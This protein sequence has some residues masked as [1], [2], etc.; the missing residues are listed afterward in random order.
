LK[1][2]RQRVSFEPFGSFES[3]GSFRS[4]PRLAY[5][6]AQVNPR[7]AAPVNAPNGQNVPNAPN[8]PNVPNAP[9]DLLRRVVQTKGGLDA[10]KG[11]RTVV[12]DADMSVTTPRGPTLIPTKTYVVYPDK[13]RVDATFAGQ[14]NVQAYNAGSAWVRDPAGV[15]AAPPAMRSDFAAT[16]RRDTFPLLIAA[17]E[18]KL[19]VRPLPE[20]G[21]DGVTLKVIEI[22]GEGLTPV[23]LY[24]DQNN[25]IVRQ[26]YTTP[27]PDGRP[28]QAEEV[29]SDYR[30]VNGIEVPFRASVLRDGRLILDRTLKSVAF[31]VPVDAS[32]FQQPL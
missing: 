10:L 29:F 26:V 15:S 3:F 8:A 18:G 7:P 20:E 31:N 9:N 16:V 13:F 4:A 32:L 25:R 28:S 11:I 6:Q 17:S 22:S 19:A 5:T 1:K 2:E 27:G 30:K 23:R 12:V 14:Q 24:I 21:K